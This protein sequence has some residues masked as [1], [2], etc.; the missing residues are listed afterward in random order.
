M[1]FYGALAAYGFMGPYGEMPFI[2]YKVYLVLDSK[3]VF[4]VDS[5]HVKI[6]I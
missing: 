6:G 4:S 1:V 5:S 3:P 2:A